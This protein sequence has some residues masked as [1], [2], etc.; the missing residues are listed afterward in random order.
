ME[1]VI[2]ASQKLM[3]LMNQAIAREIQVSI[4]YFWQHVL[5]KGVKGFAVKD[6]FKRIA[7]V[8]MKHAEVIAER[9]AYLGGEPT[10]QSK[11]IH[12]GKNLK[13]MLEHDKEAE[14]EAIELYKEIIEVAQQEGDITTAGLFRKIL[15][16]EEEHHDTFLG[17]LEDF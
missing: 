1:V 13:E 17:L 14:E 4:Q 10:T 3:D 16:E 11:P 12:V 8:E 9:L 6:E 2:M 15:A 7:I 5:W